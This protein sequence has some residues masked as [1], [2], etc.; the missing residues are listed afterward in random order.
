[1]E[2][3][4]NLPLPKAQVSLLKRSRGVSLR[5]KVVNDYKEAVHCGHVNQMHLWN[6]VGYKSINRTLPVPSLVD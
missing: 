1:M 5:A 2:I 4:I 6:H 3:Y